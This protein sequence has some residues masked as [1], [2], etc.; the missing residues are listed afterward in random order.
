MDIPKDGIWGLE[1]TRKRAETLE[2]MTEVYIQ[3]KY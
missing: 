3:R 1:N 2:K